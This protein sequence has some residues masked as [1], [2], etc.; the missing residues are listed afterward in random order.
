M[1]PAAVALHFVQ[2]QAGGSNA[3]VSYVSTQFTTVV[4]QISRCICNHCDYRMSNRN[5]TALKDHL[6]NYPGYPHVL[7]HV[8]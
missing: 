1:D 7:Q 6:I 2:A 8:Q 4:G 3:R 5:L